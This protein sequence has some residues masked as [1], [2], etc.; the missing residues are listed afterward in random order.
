MVEIV[1]QSFLQIMHNR[2]EQNKC[3]ISARKL[4]DWLLEEKDI[5][6]REEGVQ[7]GQDLFATN[8]IRHGTCTVSDCHFKIECVYNILKRT[9]YINVV[10]VYL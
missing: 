1:S 6:S 7:L 3:N 8:V 4:L 9:V 5:E 2:Q 10:C